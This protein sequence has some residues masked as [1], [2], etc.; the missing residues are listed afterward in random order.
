MESFVQH[1]GYLAL[2]LLAV[3]SSAC[4]PIPSEVFYVYA[5]ALATSAVTG[6][7]QLSLWAVIV[8]GTIGSLVGSQIAYELGRSAGRTIVDRWGKWLL[9]THRDLDRAE[10]WF[11]HYGPAAV[12]IGR[13]IPVVRSFVSL[14]AGI[15]EMRRGRFAVLTTI[16][17]AVWVSLLAALG[18][19][20]G[21]NWHRVSGDFHDAEL[22][23]IVLVVALIAFG[24]WHRIRV[25]RRE[26]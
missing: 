16:G 15:A 18:Y 26:A 2:F 3:A 14:P 21:R 12:L 10:R 22:P 8:V 1:S 13:V 7:A 9:L 25:V 20:A 24:L 23:A 17:S 6:H 19:A 4:V 11:E 5:G